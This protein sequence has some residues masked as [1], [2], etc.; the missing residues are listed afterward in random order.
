MGEG[1]AHVWRDYLKTQLPNYM[2]PAHFVGLTEFPLTPNGKIDRKAL[3]APER[4]EA[5]HG[6]VAPR[7]PSSKITRFKE[8]AMMI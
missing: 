4:K 8:S 6:Y 3:P 1:N 5:E 2:V 7:T